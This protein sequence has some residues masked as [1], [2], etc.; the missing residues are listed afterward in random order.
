M[1]A[2]NREIPP[3]AARHLVRRRMHAHA[4]AGQTRKEP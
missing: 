1:A 2:V 3:D 4:R